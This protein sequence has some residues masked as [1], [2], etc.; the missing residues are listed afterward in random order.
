MTSNQ[1]ASSSYSNVDTENISDIKCC[2]VQ[3]LNLSITVFFSIDIP[4]LI[5]N[6]FPLSESVSESQDLRCSVYIFVESNFGHRNRY[7]VKI[8]Y[9]E[10]LFSAAT[11]TLRKELLC[12]YRFLSIDHGLQTRS[13]NLPM[14]GSPPYRRSRRRHSLL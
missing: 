14:P 5:S 12:S 4:L 9:H 3:E 10:I 7:T 6:V 2:Q 13:A 11:D 8:I 1:R